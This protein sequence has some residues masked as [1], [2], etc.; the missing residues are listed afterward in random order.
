VDERGEEIVGD[1]MLLL[2]NA[3]YE[4]I[5]FTLPATQEGELWERL[6]DTA[7]SQDMPLEYTGGQQYELQGRAT[8]VL[9]IKAQ[10]AEA[11]SSK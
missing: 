4:A 8:A 5:P 10:P 6:L 9:R 7:D 2:L 3:H 11:P 1:I